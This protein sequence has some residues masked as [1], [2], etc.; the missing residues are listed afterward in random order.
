[1]AGSVVQLQ[2]DDSGV[3]VIYKDF[4]ILGDTSTYASRAA[5]AAQLQGKHQVFHEALMAS[6]H[7][8]TK[9]EIL[10]LAERVSIDRKRLETDMSLPKWD[11]LLE[12]NR[13]LAGVLNISGTPGF[14]VGDELH[15]G[16]VGLEGLKQL[17]AKARGK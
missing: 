5:L 10:L 6:E 9:E 1:V 8:L 17:V 16:I 3:R 2:K 7:D 14:I 4:P 11:E 13:A 15:L 12:R